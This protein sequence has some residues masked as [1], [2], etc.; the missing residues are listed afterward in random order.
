VVCRRTTTG[1][2]LPAGTDGV[3]GLPDR[4]TRDTYPVPVGA[5]QFVNDAEANATCLRKPLS[6]SCDIRQVAKKAGL[7]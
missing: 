1:P 4:R 7:G 2:S 5:E 3:N 6:A